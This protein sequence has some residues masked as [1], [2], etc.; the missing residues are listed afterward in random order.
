MTIT[1]VIANNSSHSLISTSAQQTTDL[2]SNFLRALNND[3]RR[4]TPEIRY[5]LYDENLSKKFDLR[6]KN[7]LLH[8]DKNRASS[9]TWKFN[10]RDLGIKMMGDV[11]YTAYSTIEQC[12]NFRIFPKECWAH[13]AHRIISFGKELARAANNM[14]ADGPDAIHP[15][16]PEGIEREAESKRKEAEEDWIKTFVPK[17]NQKYYLSIV[18][19]VEYNSNDLWSTISEQLRQ[20]KIRRMNNSKKHHPEIPRRVDPLHNLPFIDEHPTEADTFKRL[21]NAAKRVI[22]KEQRARREVAKILTQRHSSIP[23]GEAKNDILQP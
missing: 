15:M 21:E 8:L 18:S 11:S 23:G 9:R 22:E 10:L 7:L 6:H 3:Y 5:G 16:T 17:E 20:S 2:G 12:I 14:G 13:A 4:P 1:Q 19:Y